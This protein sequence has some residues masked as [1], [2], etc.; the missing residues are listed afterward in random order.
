MKIGIEDILS[1]SHKGVK[2]AYNRSDLAKTEH[3][4]EW[5]GRLISNEPFELASALYTLLLEASTDG[6]SDLERQ[7]IHVARMVFVRDIE[8]EDFSPHRPEPHIEDYDAC[9]RTLSKWFAQPEDRNEVPGPADDDLQER[10][11]A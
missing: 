1:M 11:A 8:P 10:S 6:L 3:F 2:L 5:I 9:R 7:A 4:H